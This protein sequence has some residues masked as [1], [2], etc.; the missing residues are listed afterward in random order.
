MLASRGH[1]V[2]YLERRSEG[3]LSLGDLPVDRP[4]R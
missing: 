2:T 3:P 4:E 1:F